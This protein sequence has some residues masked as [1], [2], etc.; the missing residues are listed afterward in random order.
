MEQELESSQISGFAVLVRTSSLFGK[1]NKCTLK[2]GAFLLFCFVATE[3]HKC[4]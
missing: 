4:E 3:G 2:S 1:T